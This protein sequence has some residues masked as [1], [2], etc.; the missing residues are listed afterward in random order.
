[1]KK[2]EHIFVI[3]P[4]A[5]TSDSTNAIRRAIENSAH[6]ANCEIYRTREPGDAT[7]FV[8]K[9]CS[10]STGP[11]RFYACGG[12]GTLNE[13]VN[14]AADFPDASV[15]VF[16]CGSGNDFVKYYGGAEGFLN[17][18]ALID[19]TET[20]IDLIRA[21]GKYCINVFDFGFDTAVLTAMQ[22]VREK[23]LL[24]GKRAYFAGVAKAL[25]S[26]MKTAC[27][28]VA[29][30]ERISEGSCL[31]C[32]VANGTYVGSSFKCAPRSDNSDGLLELCFVRPVSRLTFFRLIKYYTKGEHIDNPKF[33]NCMVYRRAKKIKIE[34]GGDFVYALDGELVFQNRV[35]V[36]VVEKALR[37]IVPHGVALG[38]QATFQ[39][40]KT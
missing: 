12:D 22:K 19:G 7:A 33:K 9:K 26:S 3:N 10:Q 38:K 40:M 23:K 5:G 8:A 31:L 37:F 39:A 35:C 21:N 32:T 15:G 24:S 2:V 20:R 16:P 27:Q 11:L 34:G 28:L 17:I 36:E 6:A 18:D 30:G 25:F 29:D 13:V 4:A 14:G 1:V